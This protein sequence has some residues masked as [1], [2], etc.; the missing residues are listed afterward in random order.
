MA[1]E[2]VDADRIYIT[3]LSMGGMGTFEMVHRW[4]GRFAAA[5]PICG[6]GNTA[7]YDKR[8]KDVAFRVYHGDA[9]AVVDVTLSRKMVERLKILRVKNVEYTEYPSV[10]HNSWDKAFADPDFLAWMF[11]HAQKP[12]K[13]SRKK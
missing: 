4:P 2:A 9:D 7:A 8:V 10:N 11:G 12:V 1:Q 3:G 13:D 5:L 6:G